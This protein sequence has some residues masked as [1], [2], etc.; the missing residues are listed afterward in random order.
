MLRK[1]YQEIKQRWDMSPAFS[2]TIS[3]VLQWCQDLADK[4]IAALTKP[5]PQLIVPNPYLG[6]DIWEGLHTIGSLAN[7]WDK[8][9]A[10][11]IKA[12]TVPE[13]PELKVYRALTDGQIIGI[14]DK[15]KHFLL[16][17]RIRDVIDADRALQ[18]EPA[19]A[20]AKG[21]FCQFADGST[22]FAEPIEYKSL[23][24]D[25]RPGFRWLEDEQVRTFK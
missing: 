4:E 7:A 13:K 20:I 10:A 6:E 25:S 24:N 1:E 23:E 18:L 2:L 21:K 11:R 15:S 5:S 16:C 9:F 14:Y 3:D 19:P 8:G 17:N 12:A 22:Y